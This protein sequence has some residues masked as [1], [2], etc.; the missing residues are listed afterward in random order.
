[1]TKLLPVYALAALLS[2]TASQMALADPLD[3]YRGNG[4][5]PMNPPFIEAWLS[6]HKPVN[7]DGWVCV[8]RP[9]GWTQGKND[10]ENSVIGI[11]NRSQKKK[12]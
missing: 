9:K 7:G 5:V 8:K 6:H 4:I 1:M 2:I 10:K 11:D 3:S 12:K